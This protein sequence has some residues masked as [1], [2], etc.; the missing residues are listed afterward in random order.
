MRG[1]DIVNKWKVWPSQYR[2]RHKQWD[3]YSVNEGQTK[4]IQSHT[5]IYI[6]TSSRSYLSL[7]THF[8]G[9]G[10]FTLLVLNLLPFSTIQISCLEILNIDL[11]QL[12]VCLLF[13]FKQRARKI[14][15]T[16]R[17]IRVLFKKSCSVHRPLCANIDQNIVRDQ[18]S[19][20]GSSSTSHFT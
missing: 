13:F 19:N 20:W 18:C 1:D 17:K 16:L 12:S 14:F 3:A 2:G 8:G 7:G 15:L 9:A 5:H 4:A 6:H 10:D 11:S